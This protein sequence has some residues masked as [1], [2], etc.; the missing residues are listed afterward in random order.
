M[1][2]YVTRHTVLNGEHLDNVLRSVL[3]FQGQQAA[4][5]TALT[6]SSTG[7]AGTL[8]NAATDVENE[9]A[10][11][12]SLADKTTAEAA[13]SDSAD[14]LATLFAKA[15]TAAT[16]LGI[17]TVTDNGGGSGGGDTL[18]AMATSVTGAATGVQATEWNA[19]VDAINNAYYVC[20]S[21]VNKLAT[22]TGTATMSLASIGGNTYGA[23][24]AALSTDGG[25]AADP[26]VSKADADAALA[27]FANNA[28]TIAATL[29]DVID[30]VSPLEAVAS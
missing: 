19:A 29:N 10:S 9:A 30:G 16:A 14:A 3:Q 21:L 7:T 2:H 26:G 25:T 18:A 5:A 24:V 1:T 12:S 6:D 27:I 22:A 13:L 11:G 4:E 23:T 15:N 28:A 17:A 20:G 8:T